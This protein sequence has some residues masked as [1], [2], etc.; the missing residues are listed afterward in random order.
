MCPIVFFSF[1]IKACG[2]ECSNLR[3][4]AIFKGF[5]WLL[6]SA[7]LRFWAARGLD[8]TKFSIN[9]KTCFR[10]CDSNRFFISMIEMS[11]RV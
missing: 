10:R 4:M 5:F 8:Y 3:K 1:E 6:W 2:E 9:D 7:S 11:Q